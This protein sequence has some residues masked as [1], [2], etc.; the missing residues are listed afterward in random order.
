M[1]NFLFSYWTIAVIAFGMAWGAFMVLGLPIVY[2]QVFF[3][4][5]IAFSLKKTKLFVFFQALLF[6]L[7]IVLLSIEVQPWIFAFLFILLFLTFSNVATEKVPLFISTD[8]SLL[9][10]ASIVKNKNN[11]IDLGCGTGRVLFFMA[12]QCPDLLVVGIENSLIPYLTAYI[13]RLFCRHRSRITLIFGSIWS[14]N[15]SSSDCVYVYLSP[16]P[17][18]KIWEKFH[19]EAKCNAI[20]ISNTFLVPN[21]PYDEMHHPKD[22]IGSR[23]YIWKNEGQIR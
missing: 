3:A 19:S 14:A 4:V 16:A 10:L 1:E 2:G 6:P 5:L 11:F 18:S 17:M 13:K 20:L 21:I 15:I 12:D 22:K 7:I 23:I 8:K 9:T